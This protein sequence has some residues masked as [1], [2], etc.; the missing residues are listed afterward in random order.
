MFHE[1]VAAD[2]N[3]VCDQVYLKPLSGTLRMSGLL[4]ES[5][6]FGCLSDGC[7]RVSSLTLARFLHFTSQIAAGFSTIYLMFS[8][9]TG[10]DGSYLVRFVLL[11]E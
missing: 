4:I 3:I 10:G 9:L 7:G 2:F 8:V 6:I 11:F 1:S 5:Y